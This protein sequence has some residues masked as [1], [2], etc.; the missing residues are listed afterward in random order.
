METEINPSM[1]SDQN[2]L[3]LEIIKKMQRVGS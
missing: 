2:A 3:N 1:L